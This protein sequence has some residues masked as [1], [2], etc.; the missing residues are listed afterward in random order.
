[1]KGDLDTLAAGAGSVGA[2]LKGVRAR[3]KFRKTAIGAIVGGILGY[4][5]I[6]V[7]DQFFYDQL[8]DRMVILISFATGWIANELTDVLE[9][10]VQV[11]WEFLTL[12]IRKK[13]KTTID[14][15]DKT[16]PNPRL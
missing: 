7:I 11:G 13:L 16:E 5:S 1:M 8:N 9:N 12:Y 4:L 6:G 14:E 3:D 15:D 2:V 10:V